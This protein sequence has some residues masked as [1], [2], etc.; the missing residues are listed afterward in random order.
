MNME[1]F[2][3]RGRQRCDAARSPYPDGKLGRVR[4]PADLHFS[5]ATEAQLK[6]MSL[7]R[8]APVAVSS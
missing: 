1:I 6:A 7:G 8:P 4:Y 3:S 2:F 5:A